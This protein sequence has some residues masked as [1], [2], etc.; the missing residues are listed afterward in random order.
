M[1]EVILNAVGVLLIIGLLY[2][3]NTAD[4]FS[5]RAFWKRLAAVGSSVILLLSAVGCNATTAAQDFANVITGI[6]NIAKAEIPALPPADGA[7]VT[8]WTTLGT[9]LDGQL[10]SCITAA[11][12]AG[13]KKPAFLA[14]FNTFAG[15]IASPAELAQLRV[16]SPGSQSKVQLWVTAIILG[17]NAALTSFGGAP[18]ATPTVAGVQPTHAELAQLARRLDVSPTY[19]L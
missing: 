17:V 6:L 1:R 9:T 2:S 18:A 8:E 19:G 10:Q 3:L 4:L 13:G 12:T 16:L 7:I 5:R 15:G 11:T 14:C